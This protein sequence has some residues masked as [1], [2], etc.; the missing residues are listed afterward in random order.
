M[1]TA[2]ATAPATAQAAGP[3]RLPAVA[4]PVRAAFAF[5][6]ALLLLVW[7]EG[8]D[9]LPFR[10]TNSQEFYELGTRLLRIGAF[11]LA[12]VPLVALRWTALAAALGLAPLLLV[13]V[14]ETGIPITVYAALVL[15]GAIAWQ[16]TRAGGA[17]L[18]ATGLAVV[19][20]VI[21][22]S[23]RRLEV[24]S[25]IRVDFEH[26]SDRLAMFA[27]YAVFA[28]LLLAVAELARRSGA[29]MARASA[30]E[31]R[32]GEVERESAVTEERARLARDL[33]DVVA[34]HVSLIAVR[35]ETAPY[36]VDDLGTGG[37]EV[38]DEIAADSRRAL[39]ELRGVL[40][41]LRRSGE[42]PA[43][44]P[45]PTA[46]D[47]PALVRRAVE[48]GEQVR[49]AEEPTGLDQVPAAA[50][51][52]GYR[53]V[54]EALT[55]SRRH[56]PG[57]PVQLTVRG[58]AGG[59]WLRVVTDLGT[60]APPLDPGRGLTGARER[61]EALGGRFRAGPVDTSFVVEADLSAGG[62][63]A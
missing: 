9:Q 55:N 44:A 27:A 39:D 28:G 20:P 15:G 32:A 4:H 41:V 40:G 62:A 3:R 21:L 10:S 37:R 57:R 1:T 45:Q 43:L 56:A 52:A 2:P 8:I 61:V 11:V 6:C 53:V 48:T 19:A 59:L 13:L 25:T 54:Q 29:R 12:A 63:G 58:A 35:A 46:A 51:Y 50:G 31:A 42:D 34:H 14:G 30:L 33:H 7:T 24:Y 16:R 36:T 47:V 18:A 17:V 49:W 26:G 38:L 5:G 23:W 22:V 60:A